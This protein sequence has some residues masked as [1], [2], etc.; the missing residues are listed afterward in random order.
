M[1]GKY[2]VPLSHVSRAK[3]Y[4]CRLAKDNDEAQVGL[5]DHRNMRAML[6]QSIV[7]FSM[8]LVAGSSPVY[9]TSELTRQKLKLSHAAC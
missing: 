1:G 5:N 6:Q 9:L 7:P 2:G 3:V 4:D 8:Q